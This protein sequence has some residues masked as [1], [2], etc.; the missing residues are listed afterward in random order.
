MDFSE[1][2]SGSPKYEPRDTYFSKKQ[3][4]LHCTVAHHP[5]SKNVFVDTRIVFEFQSA[6]YVLEIFIWCNIKSNLMIFIFFWWWSR[7]FLHMPLTLRSV[8]KFLV[9]P[10]IRTANLLE[11]HNKDTFCYLIISRN[12]F[13]FVVTSIFEGMHERKLIFLS[14]V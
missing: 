1:N 4:S 6:F 14:K 13:F 2:V 8:I 3:F 9:T 10:S 5:E 11:I 7:T 12:C